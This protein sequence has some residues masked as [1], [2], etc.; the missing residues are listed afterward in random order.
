MRDIIIRQ[1]IGINIMC[2]DYLVL[3]PEDSAI[4]TD[5]NNNIKKYLNQLNA[6]LNTAKLYVDQ[7]DW[8]IVSNEN[9]I[10][11]SKKFFR[12]YVRLIAIR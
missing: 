10:I 8:T 6:T 4:N 12:I 1:N 3:S 11:T 9:N 2:G 5:S 7:D